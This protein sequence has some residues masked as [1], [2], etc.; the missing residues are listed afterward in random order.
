MF[1]KPQGRFL[2]DSVRV[3]QSHCYC[4]VLLSELIH[5]TESSKELFS[6]SR[7]SALHCSNE[8]VLLSGLGLWWDSCTRRSCMLQILCSSA[9]AL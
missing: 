6:L 5:V 4:T 9:R 1:R 7:A 2:T 8:A 3:Q